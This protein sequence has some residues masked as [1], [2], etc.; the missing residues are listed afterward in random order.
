MSA[1]NFNL[2]NYGRC[3]SKDNTTCVYRNGYFYFN[4]RQVSDLLAW[5]NRMK[6]SDRHAWNKGMKCGFV[7]PEH[8]YF[9]Y[10]GSKSA[11]IALAKFNA[12]TQKWENHAS[13]QWPDIRSPSN[14]GYFREIWFTKEKKKALIFKPWNDYRGLL[15]AGLGP[16]S[17]RYIKLDLCTGKL[18]GITKEQFNEQERSVLDENSAWPSPHEDRF[19]EDSLV[20]IPRPVLECMVKDIS[21]C[22]E[23]ARTDQVKPRRRGM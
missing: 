12:D 17:K 3:I 5:H 6:F 2:G 1:F 13:Y 14:R 21:A 18:E 16:G 15:V 8:E 19:P 20:E 11:E 22:L 9:L 10:C 23:K 4:R 7:G